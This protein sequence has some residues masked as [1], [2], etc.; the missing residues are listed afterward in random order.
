MKCMGG[1]GGKKKVNA[2]KQSAI[3][4]NYGA[5]KKNNRVTYP[6]PPARLRGRWNK[7]RDYKFEL[8]I[9]KVSTEASITKI[10]SSLGLTE[11]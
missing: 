9:Y 5:K 1:K 3:L 7:I 11:F 10:V 8:Y 2:P 4:S 6:L